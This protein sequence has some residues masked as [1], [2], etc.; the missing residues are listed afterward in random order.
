MTIR[1]VSKQ[2]IEINETQN[3]YF[4]KAIL[5][6][7]PSKSNVSIGQLRAHANNIVGSLD[8]TGKASKRSNIKTA[9]QMICAALCG[10]A[11]TAA[12][13]LLL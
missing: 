13:M 5:F 7:R 10:G 2:I 1:G 3:D 8:S 9:V 4:E 11:V 12:I 6:V